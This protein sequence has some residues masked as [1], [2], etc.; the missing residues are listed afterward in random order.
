MLG[1][2]GGLNGL[3]KTPSAVDKLKAERLYKH[4]GHSGLNGAPKNVTVIDKMKTQIFEELTLQKP[5]IE[6]L[7]INDN[8]PLSE[9]KENIKRKML[10]E[11]ENQA[12]T[13]L[14]Y[15]KVYP[16]IDVHDYNK[17]KFYI[18]CYLDP[19]DFNPKK[20][21]IK[22][23]N[24]QN[25]V[26][27]YRPLYI[28]KATGNGYR[29]HQ[30]LVEFAKSNVDIDKDLKT[31]PNQWKKQHFM[32]LE[33]ELVNNRD[34]NLPSSWN[35]YKQHWIILLDIANSQE[36]LIIKEKAFINGIGTLRKNSGVLTNATFG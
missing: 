5:I 28:G 30:H 18:Y 31:F 26:F 3:N 16:R 2:H 13:F 29:H 7:S 4:N 1:G 10:E 35:E 8:D 22:L 14:K 19:F 32:K 17:H 23:P 25:F 27:G 34:S 11:Q 9:I 15:N 6:E 21:N 24:N 36:E 33:K 12:T 20:Y